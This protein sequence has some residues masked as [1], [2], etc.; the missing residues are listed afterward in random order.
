MIIYGANISPFVRK[1]LVVA[2]T[3]GID[4][5]HVVVMP[6]SDDPDFRRMSPLGKIPALQD[7]DL[8][9]SDSTIIC[10]YLEDRFPEVRMRP[11]SPADRA[12]ARWYEEYGD[13]KMAEALALFFFERIAKPLL[14]DNSGPDEER[15]AKLA[16]DVT[17]VALAYVEN[18]APAS[19]F[20][21]GEDLYTA[22][23]ALLSPTVN[24]AYAGYEI[25]AEQFPNV[26]A[27]RMRVLSHPAVARVLDT[28]KAMIKG[29][30][31]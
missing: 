9:V 25:D 28:E 8:V 24:A 13:T 10:E 4:Y 1:A 18:T 3:K 5:E 30:T 17:P 12:R 29:L 7:G 2:E 20:L 23:I 26:T 15:L 22:D 27:Y 31:G 11:D 21:F 6:G 16:A 14:G 19:G